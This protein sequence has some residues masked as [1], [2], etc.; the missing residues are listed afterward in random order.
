MAI[1][2]IELYLDSPNHIQYIPITHC[3]LIETRHVNQFKRH[4]NLHLSCARFQSVTNPQVR[5]SNKVGKLEGIIKWNRFRNRAWLLFVYW[6]TENVTELG[7]KVTTEGGEGQETICQYVQTTMRK[8]QTENRSNVM[9][10]AVSILCSYTFN[11][12]AGVVY[13]LDYDSSFWGKFLY[14]GCVF[15]L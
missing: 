14:D 11:G 9:K 8:K 10:T 15:C 4:R 7:T 6:W 3:C 1:N 12:K 5:P 13:W 2:L